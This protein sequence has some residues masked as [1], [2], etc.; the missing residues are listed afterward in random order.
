MNNTDDQ[1]E[2]QIDIDADATRVWDLIS[3]P[4][5]WINEG[6]IVDHDFDPNADINVIHHVTYG[7]FRIQTVTLDSPRHAAFLWLAGENDDEAAAK[8]GSTLVEFWIDDRDGG[9]TLRVRESG[10]ASLDMTD[11]DR[12]KTIDENTEGWEQELAAADVWAMQPWAL[13]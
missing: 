2:R 7:A 10:F 3:R 12:R 6:T 1:I 13:Q 4:G 11:A 5:W 9:V 8:A